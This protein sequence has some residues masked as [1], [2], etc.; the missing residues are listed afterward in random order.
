MC[1]SVNQ[2][3]KKMNLNSQN[4]IKRKISNEKYYHQSINTSTMFVKQEQ[5][6]HINYIKKYITYQLYKKIY[7]SP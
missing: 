6:I 7:L 1:E 3:L 4:I 2:K 5:N